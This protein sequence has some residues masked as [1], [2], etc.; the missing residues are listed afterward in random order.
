MIG[1]FEAV[2]VI[3]GSYFGLGFSDDVLEI[4]CFGEST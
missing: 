4:V 2:R 3:A 1:Y